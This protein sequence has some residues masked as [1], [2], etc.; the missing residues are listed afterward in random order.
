LR[1]AKLS[2]EQQ[3][4]YRTTTKFVKCSVTASKTV[5]VL[6]REEESAK[7]NIGDGLLYP[8][9]NVG[10]C[11]GSLSFSNLCFFN[12]KCALKI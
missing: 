7:G 9:G 10:S 12:L 1:V 6:E 11:L 5:F 2:L 4:E 8:L 3:W